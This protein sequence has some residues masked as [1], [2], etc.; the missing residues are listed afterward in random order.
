MAAGGLATAKRRRSLWRVADVH[1]PIPDGRAIPNDAGDVAFLAGVAGGTTQVGIFLP[2][3]SFALGF[4]L[5]VL[6][7]CAGPGARARRFG[8]SEQ[9]ALGVV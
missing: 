1:S 9:E 6:A 8:A 5:G 4:A 2:E 3:P 7:L